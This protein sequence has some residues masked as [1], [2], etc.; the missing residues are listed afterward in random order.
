[1]IHNRTEVL[2]AAPCLVVFVPHPP[3]IPFPWPE[4]VWLSWE[5]A[6]EEANFQLSQPPPQ[7]S[8]VPT[9]VAAHEL[10]EPSTLLGASGRNGS[11]G[12]GYDRANS[13]VLR[14]VVSGT[15][16]RMGFRNEKGFFVHASVDAV[17]ASGVGGATFFSINPSSLWGQERAAGG[18]GGQTTVWL[19]QPKG[20]H[21]R[22]FFLLFL[23]IYFAFVLFFVFDAFLRQ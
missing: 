4:K 21:L 17:K 18:G 16:A 6:V 1:M 22:L 20:T 2:K 13:T 14:L 5:V 19:E 12:D 10:Y 11:L 9:E 8:P 15:N 7:P 3:S 23:D